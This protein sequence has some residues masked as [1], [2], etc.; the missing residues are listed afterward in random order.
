MKKRVRRS[1]PTLP[2]PD[3]GCPVALSSKV[4]PG[5]DGAAGGLLLCG[6]CQELLVHSLRPLTAT[7]WNR[8]SKSEIGTIA[9]AQ[10]SALAA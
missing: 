7:E 10:R 4:L 6:N 9:S 3:C 1:A 8:L 2:C 5:V